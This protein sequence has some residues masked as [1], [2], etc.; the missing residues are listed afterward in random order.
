MSKILTIGSKIVTIGSKIAVKSFSVYDLPNLKL[1]LKA[2]DVVKDGSN[3][4]SQWNDNSGNNFHPVQAT[5]VNQPLWVDNELN[6]H[7]IVRLDGSNDFMSVAFGTTFSQPNTIFVVFSYENA[8]I[9]GYVID[10]HGVFNSIFCNFLSE[11]E[12]M[13]VGSGIISY[14]KP[15][16]WGMHVA[17][18]VFNTAN[19]RM[20]ENGVLKLSGSLSDVALNGIRIGSNFQGSGFLKGDV[21]EII[22]CNCLLTDAQR[23]STEAYLIS[24]YNIS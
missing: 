15:I 17:T 4:V 16:P 1:W 3:K 10:G 12:G 2:D 8:G 20:Y 24:K 23:Q 9:G 22:Y 11:G 19:C 18:S 6:G 5:G 21:A 7:P 14:A 13:R